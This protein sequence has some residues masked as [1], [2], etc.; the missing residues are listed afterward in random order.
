MCTLTWV[1]KFT[2]HLLTGAYACPCV[3][4]QPDTHSHSCTLMQTHKQPSHARTCKHNSPRH[5]ATLTPFN[6]HRSTNT[7]SYPLTHKHTHPRANTYLHPHTLTAHADSQTHTQ[8]HSPLWRHTC[9]HSHRLAYKHPSH[10]HCVGRH[11]HRC[12]H[13]F[14]CPHAHKHSLHLT[15]TH[16]HTLH[17]HGPILAHLL[18]HLHIHTKQAQTHVPSISLKPLTL[19][20]PLAHPVARSPSQAV[21]WAVSACPGGH[22]HS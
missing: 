18:F 9:T 8:V 19:A 15:P 5:T 14:S 22:W 1:H 21:R 2:S 13:T 20:P 10:T 4:T 11:S 16:S 7:P 12:T 6:T 3:N 17:T